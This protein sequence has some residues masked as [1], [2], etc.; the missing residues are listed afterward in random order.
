[1]PPDRRGAN[2]LAEDRGAPRPAHLRQDRR[3]HPRRGDPLRPAARARPGN[4]VA[5]RDTHS[6]RAIP[7]PAGCAPHPLSPGHGPGERVTPRPAPPAIADTLRTVRSHPPLAP[8]P[9]PASATH[10]PSSRIG[11]SPDVRTSPPVADWEAQSAAVR[12][13]R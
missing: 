6:T 8:V 1:Q 3:L 10:A 7:A 12:N 2:R 11:R 5:R 9:A 13:R 4:G